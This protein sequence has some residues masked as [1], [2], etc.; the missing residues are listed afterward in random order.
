MN[1][2]RPV[3]VN[4]SSGTSPLVRTPVMTVNK[5]GVVGV[6]WYDGRE[7]S[8]GFLG[9]LRCQNMFFTSSLDGGKTFSPEVKA[10]DG[11]S[12]SDMHVLTITDFSY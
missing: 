6:A 8:R 2:S 11:G 5:N 3:Q 7:D 1:W 9:Y 10:S 12:Y 4:R